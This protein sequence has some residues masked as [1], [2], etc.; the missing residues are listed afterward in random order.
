LTGRA[1]CWLSCAHDGCGSL[2]SAGFDRSRLPRIGADCRHTGRRHTQRHCH[3][4]HRDFCIRGVSG[5]LC[6]S[7]GDLCHSGG[8]HSSN[9]EHDDGWLDDRFRGCPIHKWGHQ[10][11]LGWGLWWGLGQP[12]EHTRHQRVA[13]V[14]SPCF[15]RRVFGERNDSTLEQCSGVGDVPAIRSLGN[16]A[17]PSRDRSF[18][19]ALIERGPEEVEPYNSVSYV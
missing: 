10:W 19:R 11:G 7:G 2:R 9:C 14:L 3:T 13:I 8:G 17:L 15:R 5:D 16:S 1:R 4:R 12:I 18:L 6:H